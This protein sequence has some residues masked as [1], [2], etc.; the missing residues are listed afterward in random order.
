[1]S[2]TLQKFIIHSADIIEF[3]QSQYNISIEQLSEEAQEHTN[4]IFKQIRIYQSRFTSRE[5]NIQDCINKLV[6][7]TDPFISSI[8]YKNL[9]N[10]N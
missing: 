1:M 6:I 3:I 2:P 5:D 10:N 8:H 4:K 7:E 9:T